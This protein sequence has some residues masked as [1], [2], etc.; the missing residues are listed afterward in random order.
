MTPMTRAGILTREGAILVALL[1][2]ASA[3]ATPIGVVKASP[4]AVYHTLTASVL[5]TGRPSATSEQV[6]HRNG[7]T[8]RF[9]KEPEVVLAELRGTGVGLNR[10]DIFAL[11]ELSFLHAESSQKRDYYLASAVYAY[12][13]LFPEDQTIES[14]P[15]DPRLGLSANLY[16]LGLTLGLA[17][18]EGDL[19]L[20]PGPRP[21]PFGQLILET[22]PEDFLWAGYRLSRFVP[23][24]QFK[25]RGLR[26]RYRQPGVG[27]PLAAEVTPE[28]Q[29]PAAERARKHIPARVKVA[30][31]ALVRIARPLEGIA[32]GQVLGQLELHTIDGALTVQINGQRVPLE[33]E[34][35]ATLAYQLEGAHVWDTELAGFLSADRKVSPEGLGMIH[36]YRPG[37]VPVVLIHG[38]ASSP[39]RW[40]EMV[41]E[42]ENDPV[43]RDRLQIW[44]FTYNTS[45]PIL[46]SAGELRDALA[47]TLADFDPE[48][49]DPALQTVVLIGH[50]QG[51]MLTRLMVTDSGTRFWDAASRKS[52][53]EIKADPELREQ[54]RKTMFFKPL[55]Y[56]TR[57]V[58]IATPHQGSFRVSTFVLNLV[59]RVVTLPIR[60]AKEMKNL[61]EQNP[62]LLM[63][64]E[65]PTAVD[66]MRPGN[67]FVKTL[68]ASPIADG[69]VAHSI[70]AV[71]GDG[72]ISSLGDGVVLY[73]SAHLEGVA[74][75]KVVRSSHS[76]QG[77]PG[78]IE[79]V[80]R[81]LREH[82]AEWDRS[83]PP[84]LED[85][86]QMIREESQ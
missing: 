3:C 20:Q 30:G 85:R 33:L 71:E 15:L 56:V 26:N 59:R 63:T 45:N 17:S 61:V 39:A 68:S 32:T 47:G 64:D 70:V 72:P 24:A 75:E 21:L 78:T 23:V 7:L 80:R 48:G 53:D 5:T 86:P 65:V 40:A 83:R 10:D 58:F 12:A 49:R 51:G 46:L 28:G 35:T 2:M 82:L 73:Q 1:C 60:L 43:L 54:L 50:S 29:G 76:T 67:R 55:P 62:D 13:F 6:L 37:R 19:D 18:P 38:T 77:E 27:A 22:D 31:T 52:F 4:Q 74:S 41:N 84:R 81:I 44:L 57:V 34:P 16:N 66:N 14:S 9:D 42:I 11:A 8:E 25:V 36:P 69:V 79:E